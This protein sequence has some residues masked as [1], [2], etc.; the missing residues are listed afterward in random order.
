MH[1]GHWTQ[2]ASAL[3][4]SATPYAVATVIATAG[5]TPR[6]AGSKIVISEADTWDSIG[7]GQFEFLVVNRARELLRN[8]QDAQEVKLFPLAAEAGQCCGGSVAVLL[9]VFVPRPNSVAIFGAGHVAQALV[10][11]LAETPVSLEWID[12][13]EGFFADVPHS[14]NLRC[15]V[16][17]EPEQA[18]ATLPSGCQVLV[19]THDHALDYRLVK[20][21][22]ENMRWSFVGLIG[23]ETKSQRFRHRLQ[24]DGVA[25]GRIEQLE[26]PVGLPG[27]KGKRPMEVAVSIAAGVL[28]RLPGEQARE[29]RGMSWKDM[30]DVL[31]QSSQPEN[32]ESD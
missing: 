18:L 5:S 30:R 26:C 3:Q 9:E 19:L 11:I 22:L 32:L 10:K 12:S 4:Q 27:V 24:K 15:R 21:L 25:P 13:R 29:N 28:S 8:G 6:N 14:M 7:G 23:S 17:V 31:R 20:A 16:L 1:S 2:A